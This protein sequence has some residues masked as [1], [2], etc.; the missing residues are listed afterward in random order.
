MCICMLT[1]K[2]FGATPA[3]I[4]S[5]EFLTKLDDLNEQFKL[6][7]LIGTTLMPNQ[8]FST[9]L[10]NDFT[11]P[12]QYRLSYLDMNGGE[13]DEEHILHSAPSRTMFWLK[14][15]SNMDTE[16]IH[17]LKEAVLALLSYFRQ[18]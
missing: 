4:S 18:R 3:V 7:S 11:D 12:I 6:K 13:Y 9:I 16:E 14:H 5:L 10:D 17:T 2:N 1:I 15:K 8:S